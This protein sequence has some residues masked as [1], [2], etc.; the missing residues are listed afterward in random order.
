MELLPLRSKG[1]ILEFTLVLGNAKQWKM[2]IVLFKTYYSILT[3]RQ[4][5][6]LSS[7]DTV[8]INAPCFLR[9]ISIFS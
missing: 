5:T 2:P 7:M 8:V 3:S 4:A 9:S 6:L 1:L